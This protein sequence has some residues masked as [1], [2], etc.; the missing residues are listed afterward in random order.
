VPA[1]D[2]LRGLAVAAVLLFHGE[3][4]GARGG[5]LGVSAFFTLSGFLITT[6]LLA[7]HDGA[8]RVALGAFWAR[9]ARRLLPAA[10]VTLGGIAL[11]GATVATGDQV[12]DLRGDALAALGYVANWR[13]LLEGR[14]YAELFSAPSPVLHFWS[15]AI[16]EQFYVLFPPVAVLLLGRRR[17]D[18]WLAV[19]LGAG[20]VAS[21]TLGIVWSA[22]RSRVYYGTDTRASEL[23]V[24]ALLA[25]ALAGRAGPVSAAGRR[26]LGAAGL[27]ALG[28]M[29][30]WWA[31]V[32]QQDLWLARGGFTM[33]AALT[34]VVITAARAD[35][36]CARLLSATPLVGLGL[37]SYGAYLYHWPLFLW[38]S[39]A[40]FDLPD[41]VLFAARVA[42]TLAAAIA[43]YRWLEQPIR[44]GRR[45]RGFLPNVVAPAGA[46]LV[47][48]AVLAVTAS[49]PPPAFHL[50][51]VSAD[52]APL[53]GPRTTVT[54]PPQAGTLAAAGTPGHRAL[55]TDRPL[56]VLVV[57]DSVAVTLGRGFELWAADT[58]RA[59]VRNVAQPWCS[60]GRHLP[61]LVAFGERDP[62]DG[63]GC[64]EWAERWAGEV[65]TFD[66]DLVVVLYTHWEAAPRLLPGGTEYRSPGDPALDAWQLGEYRAAADVLSARGARVLWS[67]VPCDD[68]PILTGDPLWHVNRRTLPRLA[69][70]HDAVEIFDLD[71]LLCP[72]GRPSRAFGGVE[73]ARPDGAHLSDAGALAV[74]RQIMTVVLSPERE[75]RDRAPEHASRRALHRPLDAARPL[76]VLVVGDSVGVTL[77]RG[78][79][80]WSAGTDDAVVV[81]AAQEYCSVGRYAPRIAGFA[82]TAHGDGCDEWESRWAELVAQFDP[83]VV[84]VSFTIWELAPRLLPGSEHHTRPGDARH[85]AWQR[86]EYLAAADV[87]SSRG[88]VVVWLTVP[89]AETEPTT[90][91]EPI[92]RLNEA[93]IRG[94]AVTHAAV[95]VVDLDAAL[96]RDGRPRPTFRG[97]EDVRPDGRHF[98]DAGATAVAAWLME[99]VTAGEPPIA[100]SSR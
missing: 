27:G 100:R 69:A 89:C 3:V 1:F 57:G 39:P 99:V 25:V 4:P 68:E 60:L 80:L 42:L 18:A 23:L 65:A 9:R 84:I 71:A 43:S 91:G 72:G 7:E 31:T 24:G 30:W 22:D 35:T 46:T 34:A 92:T 29:A 49:P 14:D 67:T 96:C 37:V 70:Q 88:A 15:L 86:S 64:S 44:H 54:A 45:L 95:D 85:D 58:G 48:V 73:D 83:D 2:G 98:S 56:R 10:L 21:S 28:L 13:F 50:E 47:A 76:R 55:P 12:R 20:V 93:T 8:G 19:A 75:E 97:V 5:F 52:R 51:P 6:L 41:P 90:P 38:L 87:L 62:A 16:E 53:S 79:E 94:V 17:S 36:V 61:R 63:V 66:P 81:N 59:I 77:G 74:A 11:F 26:V 40:R 32:D 78:F 82:T 33:H